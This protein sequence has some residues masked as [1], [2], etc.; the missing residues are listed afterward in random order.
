[1][2]SCVK[3][4]GDQSYSALKRACLRRKALFEDPH[5]PA[6]A[7]SLYYDG[8][9]G[10]A[11]RWKR[12]KVSVWSEMELRQAGPDPPRLQGPVGWPGEV[13]PGPQATAKVEGLMLGSPAV[14][15]IWKGN[16]EKGPSSV[17]GTAQPGLSPSLSLSFLM[18]KTGPFALP[19][20]VFPGSFFGIKMR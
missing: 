15:L 8:T 13:I 6:T 12:P 16:Q 14:G 4:Y 7:D 3:P 9:P 18:G 19:T 17:A 2:F 20:P 5:F 10:S 11:V 1:M